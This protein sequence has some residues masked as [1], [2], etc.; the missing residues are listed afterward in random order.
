[1]VLAFAGDR[2]AGWE[3]ALDA[4]P[5]GG[6]PLQTGLA[7]LRELS[8]DLPDLRQVIHGDLLHCNVLVEGPRVRGVLDWG[9]SMY[10]DALYDAA[11]LLFW[12]PWHPW[13]GIDIRTELDRHWRARGPVPA[14]LERRLRCYQLRIGLDHLT[15]YAHRREW[16]HLARA[17][18]Q[19]LALAT[20]G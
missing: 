13:P 9:N 15:W 11:W 20:E 5:T 6:G 17:A 1:V 18:R 4:S 10:G 3:A 12:W 14:D 2:L 16:D 7:R 19:T 8:A